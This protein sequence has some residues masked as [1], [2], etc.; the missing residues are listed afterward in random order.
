MEY[1]PLKL[2]CMHEL[3]LQVTRSPG[4]EYVRFPAPG[5]PETGFHLENLLAASPDEAEEF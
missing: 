4:F 3:E 1:D 5:F 2:I